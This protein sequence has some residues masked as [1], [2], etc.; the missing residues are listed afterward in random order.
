VTGRA[1]PTSVPSACGPSD[2]DLT[3]LAPSFVAL[4][5]AEAERA[6]DAL[7][8]LLAASSERSGEAAS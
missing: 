8:E 4:S 3:V 1:R 2:D 6:V 5:E 7:A